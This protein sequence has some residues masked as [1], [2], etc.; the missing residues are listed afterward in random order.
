MDM[1]FDRFKKKDKLTKEQ[2]KLINNYTHLENG[3]SIPEEYYHDATEETLFQVDFDRF[4]EKEFR[5]K[6]GT[7]RVTHINRDNVRLGFLEAYRDGKLLPSG[8]EGTHLFYEAIG[9]KYE[10]Q[11]RLLSD[12]ILDLNIRSKGKYNF[13]T[14]QSYT[15]NKKKEEK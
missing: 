6:D 10:T 1:I 5:K 9:F 13:R 8:T 2:K 11:R 3:L 4:L 14:K 12:L 15:Y 7:P